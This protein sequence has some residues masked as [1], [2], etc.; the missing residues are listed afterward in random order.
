[1]SMPA[2]RVSRL[3]RPMMLAGVLFALAGCASV[4][5]IGTL[6]NDPGHYNGKTVSV[7]GQVQQSAGGFGVGGYEIRDATGTLTV[8]S[9]T[10]APPPTGARVTVKGIFQSLFTLGTRSLAVLKEQ[11]RKSQ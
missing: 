3:T 9:S 6:L 4:T 7:K 5:P 11:S 10:A 2:R 1:M 8:V